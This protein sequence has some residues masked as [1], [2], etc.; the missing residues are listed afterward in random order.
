[1]SSTQ[2]IQ[3]VLFDLDGTL[4]DSAPDL[5]ASLN[6]LLQQEGM[7]TLP[8]ET[9]RPHVSKGGLALTRLAFADSHS[10]AEIEPLRLR[11]LDY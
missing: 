10:E 6:H 11:L 7:Q 5:A 8:L 2:K 9:I 4:I 1:M 3:A